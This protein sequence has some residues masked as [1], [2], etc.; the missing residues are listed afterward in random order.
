MKITLHG[1]AQGVTGSCHL[2]E[3]N[4]TKLLLDCGMNQGKEKVVSERNKN[5]G[6][7]PSSVDFVLLSHAHLDHS[8]RLP[9]LAKKGFQGEIITTEPSFKLAELIMKDSAKNMARK[10]LWKD[11]AY[12]EQLYDSN[13]VEH[14]LSSFGRFAE[15]DKKIDLGN[16][17]TVTFFDAGHILGSASILVEVEENGTKKSFVFSGDIGNINKP[18]VKDPTMPPRA[19]HV[20]MESTYGDRIH[21]PVE[22]AVDELNRVINETANNGGNVIVP[23]FAIE[24]T[25]DILFFLRELLES[26]EL[27]KDIKVFLDSPMA[28][29]AT[30]IMNQYLDWCDEDVQELLKRNINPFDFPNLTMTRSV[31]ESKT[32][33][34][35]K[36][37]AVILAGS[38]MADGGRIHHHLKHNIWR[39]E[40]SIVSLNYAADGT[41]ARKLIDGEKEIFL[42]G[43]P[44]PVKAKISKIN[45][46]SSHADKIGLSNWHRSSGKPDNTFLVH[47]DEPAMNSFSDELKARGCHVEMP[48]LHQEYNL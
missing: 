45:G 42:Q 17:I 43:R 32:I 35:I 37:G 18:I 38:G 44:V 4:K 46:L 33:N 13:D 11:G 47:G 31:N 1:A 39:S 14:A 21:R 48:T 25:Q 3:V 26:R 36:H 8:G 30:E 6:F 19:D 7:E 34:N 40:C 2:L 23:L 16:G 5:F 20:V 15:Y 27:P 29:S 9:Y 12:V 28:I 41:L 24:R 10:A 22:E